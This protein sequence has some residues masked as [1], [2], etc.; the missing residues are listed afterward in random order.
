MQMPVNWNQ[1]I[2][3]RKSLLSRLKHWDDQKSW[4]DFYGIYS[5]LIYGA[6]IKAGLREAE[7]EDVVQ[8]TVIAVAKAI[9][10]FKYQP[11]KCAFKTWL[12]AITRRQ[13][14][15]Q[16]RKRQG[17]G[18]LLEPLPS[19]DE[20]AELVNDI[21]DPAS[22]ALDETWEQ[23]WERNLLEAAAERVKR[24]VSPA[25]FQIFEYHALQGHGVSETAQALGISAA[26]V[27]LVKH[28]IA[29]Q[30]REEVAYLRT[31]YV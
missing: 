19:Q 13:V 24:R 10:G 17:K 8:D 25:Q 28:R 5:R 22:Q 16:F 29:K 7:A 11:E 20:E 2:P 1:L 26:K 21:P 12:H 30:V 14:A 3:T 23:E 6:A 15:N 4:Q 9:Q 27:Y 31:K 18:R